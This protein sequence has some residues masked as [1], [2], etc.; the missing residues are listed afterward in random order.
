MGTGRREARAMSDSSDD[1]G[2]TV[3]LTR[4]LAGVTAAV[5]LCLMLAAAPAGA[6]TVWS[7]KYSG[8]FIDGTGSSKGQFKSALG[9]IDYWPEGQS[10]IVNVS[11]DPSI[12][13]KFNKNGTPSKFSALNSGAGRDYI[14]LGSNSLGEI[15]VDKSSNP[16]SK[17]N[18]YGSASATGPFG[19]GAFS[20]FR[21]NGLPIDEFYNEPEPINGC[22]ADAGPNGEFFH[23]TD[24]N[25]QTELH[26]RDPETFDQT[27][28][29]LTEQTF[30]E[31]EICDLKIDADR[32]F[33]GF[34]QLGFFESEETGKWALKLPANPIADETGGTATRLPEQEQRYR[35]NGACCGQM[36]AGGENE[37]MHLGIDR[38]NNDVFLVE[39]VSVP[40]FGTSRVSVY[41]EN[42]GLLTQ[43]GLPAG[44][45]EGLSEAGGI[46]VDPATHDVYVTNNRV[47]AGE[48]RRIEKFVRD[49]EFTVPDTDTE[50][51]AQPALPGEATLRGVLNPDTVET[52]EC[53]FEWGSKPGLGTKAPCT[54]GPNHTGTDDIEVTAPIAGLTKGTKYWVKLFAKNANGV[55]SDGGPEQFLAQSKPISTVFAD[56]VNTDGVRLNA[57]VDPNGG[58]TWYYWEYG[59]TDA[60]GSKTPEKRLRRETSTETELPTSLTQAFNV[61]DLIIGLQNDTEYHFRLVTR[62][63]Q[64]TSIS[65]DQFI[66]TYAA[67]SEPSCSNGLVRQQTGSHF[68]PD[69]RAYELAST[70]YSGGADVLSTIVAGKD[71]LVAYP[72][73]SGTLLYSLDSSI[74][75]G[76][77]GD[78]TNLGPDPYVAVRGSE[79]WTTSYVGLPSGGMTDT[80][81]FGSPLLEADSALQQFAFGGAGICD[82]CFDD[83]STNIPLRRSSGVLE[84]GMAGELNP[85]A[86]PAGEVRKRF[87]SDGSTFVFGA[88]K[89]FEDEGNEGSVSIYTR[90]LQSG[91]TQVVSTEPDGDTLT[92]TVAELD[93]SADG[94]RVLIG[95][96]VGSPDSAGNRFY[97]LYMHVGDSPNSIPVVESS[98]GVNFAGM[99]ADGAKV[100]FTTPDPLTDDGDAASDLF[101]ADVGTSSTIS[102][103]STGTGSTGNT[104]ACA[105][106]GNWNMVS[107]GSPCSVVAIAGGG[108]V[109][110]EEG[111]VYFLSPELLDGTE[112]AAEP[113]NQPV[114]N[115]PNLYAVKPGQAPEFVATIDSGNPAV[116]NG[117]QNS[118]RHNYGDFQVTPNGRFAVF[119]TDRPLS[120]Y[121]N[122]GNTEVFRYESLDDQDL[123]ECVS[124]NPT[125]QPGL[126]DVSLSHHGLNMTDDGRVFFTTLE[127]FALR[128]TNGKRDVY[129]WTDGE[130]KLISLGLGRDDSALLSVTADGRDVFFFTRDILSRLDANGN[131]VKVYDAREGGGFLVENRSQPC[132]AAD[133][134]RGPGTEQ[135][136]P[137]PIHTATGEGAPRQPQAAGRCAALARKAKKSS[138]QARKLRRRAADAASEDSARKLRKRAAKLTRQAGAL[139]RSAKACRG[140][141]G[142][143]GK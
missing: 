135:P 8:Q 119:S 9:G 35:L 116:V 104:N 63:E 38:S 27:H 77:T 74:V 117:V 103:L 143:G 115:Q 46:T 139:K 25:G 132:A 98:S 41:D 6:K 36:V 124:C 108:G 109:A 85:A 34:N 10:L 113:E 59:T 99:T 1:R 110:E 16:A 67:E 96:Q 7:Y 13:A 61:S 37:G 128:D 126:T 3:G 51:P 125:N 118:E 68:L 123:I 23:L 134:C 18:I 112:N 20:A 83:G 50:Q 140:S 100:F 19:F 133:E 11:G 21:S 106:V 56:N 131:A 76:A 79:G 42:G 114:A 53:Y 15:S 136:G 97:D 65:D 66:V 45:Y 121:A 129:Q 93:I 24:S 54:E 87:S 105:P 95:K 120:G 122:L 141:S 31:P 22:G 2:R 60:Y 94:E 101:V 17:G 81:Q 102:R 89:K 32:N 47:Y 72:D 44:S 29:Y 92:G 43:F 127:S 75:P 28:V 78:P 57:T 90:N 82:P 58:R 137:Q 80:G 64:G 12:I 138:T 40:T 62:N 33:Y 88:D 49:Q 142:E 55:I 14:D 73:A 111:T 48:T 4:V 70:R 52:T 71:P 91:E 5:A 69:C 130:M 84:K 26:E 30:S 107:G 39:R 86:D